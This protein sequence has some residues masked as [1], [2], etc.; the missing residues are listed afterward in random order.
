MSE[1]AAAKKGKVAAVLD[2][3]KTGHVRWGI[4][5]LLFLSTVI[6]Y[7][8]RQVFSVLA[9]QIK[10]DLLLTDSGYALI[11]NLF[12]AGTILGLIFSG[13]FMDKFGARLGFTIAIVVWSVAGGATAFAPTLFAIALCRFFLGL[14]ESG[15]WPAASKAVAEWFPAKER[16]LA[17]GFFNG[18]VSIG[19]ILAPFLVPFVVLLTGSWRWAFLAT[20]FLA[21]PWLYFWRRNYFPTSDHPRVKPE[22]L[23][24]IARD[25]VKGAPGKPSVVLRTPQFWG[26]FGARLVTS[27]V[28]FFISYWIFNYLHR[29]FGFNLIKMAAVAWI[30]FAF[31]DAGNILGGYLS[32]KLVARGMAPSRA[33]RLLMGVGAVLM[34]ANGFTAFTHSPV[35]ALSL[36]SLLTLA[37][38][39]WVSNMLGLVSDSFA[40]AHVG[41]VMSW[42]GLGQYAGSTAF[43]WFIGYALDNFGMGYAPVFLAAAA[44]PLIGYIFTLTLNRK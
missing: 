42:T 3:L 9:P 20:A 11:I 26:L 43:T 17:M 1:N 32:G 38:G 7:L 41:T 35:V 40:S 23:E 5:L 12:N 34:A 30:P 25:R 10:S 29:E 37:W 13:P 31:A 44:L 14:G 6:N 2:G 16:A 39:I 22:E 27:P 18:G 33:R 4:L 21:I 36:I 28:W 24:L 8:D 19:A 15:N